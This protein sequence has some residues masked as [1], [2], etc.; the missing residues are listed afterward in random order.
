MVSAALC[1]AIHI[2]CKFAAVSFGI[3]KPPQH[4]PYSHVMT[5]AYP[6]NRIGAETAVEM[7]FTR[8]LDL[9]RATFTRRLLVDV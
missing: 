6:R 1:A 4:A 7:D 2:R 8:P 3:Q 5:I 9:A